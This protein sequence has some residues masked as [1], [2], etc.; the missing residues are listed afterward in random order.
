MISK[1]ERTGNGESKKIL[2]NC[3]KS[4][5]F[6]FLHFANKTLSNQSIHH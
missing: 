3:Y 1:K 4:N 2:L 6:Y 5:S